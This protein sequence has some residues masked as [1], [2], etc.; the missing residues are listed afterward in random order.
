MNK[1][2]FFVLFLVNFFLTNAK[3]ISFQIFLASNISQKTTFET[4]EKSSNFKTIKDNY[5][6][7]FGITNSTHWLKIKIQNLDKNHTYTIKIATITPDSMEFYER[8]GQ[9]IRKQFSGEAFVSNDRYFNYHFNAQSENATI[10]LKVIGNGQPIA[11]PISII[12][13][14]TN[15][16]S[17]KSFLFIGILYGIIILILIFNLI[18]YVSS[19]EKLYGYILIY[20]ICAT[21]V[22]LY[23]DGFIKLFFIQDSIYWNNQF[24]AIALCGSFIITNFYIPEFLNIKNHKTIY[25]LLFKIS[26]F[27]FIILLILSFWHPYGFNLYIIINLFILTAEAI[28]LFLCVL[29]IRN[30][31]KDFFYI[32]LA[33][34]LSLVFFGTIS[35][36]YFLGLLPINIFT[37]NN[38][39]FMVFPQILIQSFALGKR[40]SIIVKEKS[41]LQ[42]S[43]LKI[44]EQHSQSLI[45]TLEN[46]R[47]RISSE[48]HDSIGQNILV[49]RNRILL[50]I[51]KDNL[52]SFQTEK[53]N[54]LASLT[55]ETLEELRVI[56]HDLRPSTLDSIG[57]T[58]S[59]QQMVDKVKK[60][61][62]ISINF[63]CETNIDN[64]LPKNMEINFYRILQELFNNLLKHSKATQS[65]IVIFLNKNSLIIHFTDNGIG[66]DKNNNVFM[67]NTNGL[68]NINDRVNILNG[69]IFIE[70][71]I[72]KGT[73]IEIIIPIK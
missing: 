65:K 73:F 26:T 43:L 41:V 11:L 24:V 70:S 51:K 20:N 54:N 62:F 50:M 18:L 39:Y 16:L 31:E 8:Y 49:I 1:I 64:L 3:D 19:L 58:V 66:F 34:V 35:Q 4:I 7:N 56:A 6:L 59:I 63:I 29:Y 10:F 40:L 12:D 9:K 37:Q 21:S 45:L 27:L 15:I 52:P 42:N 46:E 57:L 14:E 72:N 22:M 17:T 69:T 47:K 36:L 67:K 2:V 61:T 53:L 44:S 5:S 30:K 13:N 23:F 32:Q 48:F 38:I 55:S 28:L 33:S 25:N 71:E 60:S 68:S